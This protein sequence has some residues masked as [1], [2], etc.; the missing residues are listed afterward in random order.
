MAR[1]KHGGGGA[2]LVGAAVVALFIVVAT[3]HHV[4]SD[5]DG[6]HRL[7]RRVPTNDEC[8]G[9]RAFAQSP[10]L[11]WRLHDAFTTDCVTATFVAQYERGC[12]EMTSLVE[13]VAPNGDI[14][15]WLDTAK[16]VDGGC[17]V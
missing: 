15:T 1:K 16:A 10:D 9:P 14:Q 17:K 12:A 11:P 2:V 8:R 7:R 4:D 3:H 5:E 13:S 6:A